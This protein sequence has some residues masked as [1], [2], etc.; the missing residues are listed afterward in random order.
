[1]IDADALYKALKDAEDLARQRVLDTES[2]LPYPNNLN[3]SY[4]R[5]LAQ[6]DERTKAKE[7]VADAPT[8][9]AVPV[10]HGRW[11]IGDDGAL[12]CSECSKIPVNRIIVDE[13]RIFDMT[14]IKERMKYCPNCGSRM[15]GKDDEHHEP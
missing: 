9:D 13:I 12:H 10:V 6:M 14:P 5:Y 3:P 8:V 2:T 11:F 15:D 1:M 4:T 7:M